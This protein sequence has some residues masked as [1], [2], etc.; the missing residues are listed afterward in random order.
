MNIL[1]LIPAPSFLSSC[2][3]QRCFLLMHSKGLFWDLSHLFLLVSLQQT[4]SINLLSYPK[5]K[6]STL[7]DSEAHLV[8]C[9]IIG[10]EP[11]FSDVSECAFS[12]TSDAHIWCPDWL[13]LEQNTFLDKLWGANYISISS[14]PQ[15]CRNPKEQPFTCSAKS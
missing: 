14:Q 13:S 15:P 1:S 7:Q 6:K 10:A 4:Q 2:L 11:R 3:C 5:E 9:V 8:L 12:A